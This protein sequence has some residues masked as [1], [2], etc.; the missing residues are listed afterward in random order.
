MSSREHAF[1]IGGGPA[2][3]VAAIALRRKGLKVTVADGGEAP[4]DKACG[5]G[6][7]PT[8]L[9]AL[10]RL[11]ITLDSA[12]GRAF[13]GVRFVNARSSADATFPSRAGL[14]M[15]RIALHRQLVRAAERAG[16][17]LFW[18]TPASYISDNHVHLGNKKFHAD[19]VI[20]ADG[21]NSRVRRWAGLALRKNPSPRFAYR[22]HFACK[23]WTDHVEV[24][25]AAQAQLY[26]TPV[27]AD[28]I[29]IVVLSRNSRL[30]V[31]EAL[32]LF[33]K[34]FE[35]LT[36]CESTT[37]ERGAATGNLVLRAVHAGR[38]ALLGDA[39][40]TVDAITGEGLSLAFQQAEA[41]ADA[42]AQ[43]NLAHY[44]AAHSRLYRRPL[45]VARQLLL[46]ENYSWLEKRVLQ[47]FAADRKLFQRM[48]AVHLDDVSTFSFATAG[49]WL[50]WRLLAAS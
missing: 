36:A 29:G 25:W 48:L 24:H 8:G 1:V 16:V 39:S 2:G 4:G 41:L 38:V 44:G 49:A 11:G 28:E 5:E 20:G 47:A 35:K 22:Q 27:S 3:L 34:I 50:G 37:T 9:S 43:G 7:L 33:P 26:V 17:N 46:L 45:W 6:I 18:H 32:R 12:E 42:I 15:R 13:R 30:R 40:G 19:W 21:Y 10:E 14:G 31:K 23:P